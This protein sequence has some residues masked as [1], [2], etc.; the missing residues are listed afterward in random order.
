MSTDRVNYKVFRW[1]FRNAVNKKKNW[2]LRIMTKCNLELYTDL[3]N[4]LHKNV[5]TRLEDF[6]FD[7]Y[8]V[9]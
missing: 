8:K 1:A 2:C 4:S 5:I 3:E 9:N 7:K 6:L